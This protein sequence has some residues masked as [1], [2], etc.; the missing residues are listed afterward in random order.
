MNGAFEAASAHRVGLL[1]MI[2]VRGGY[3]IFEQNALLIRVLA[4]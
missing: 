2:R 3:G 4:W 1:K